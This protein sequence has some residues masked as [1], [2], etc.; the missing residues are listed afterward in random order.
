MEG[1]T[2]TLSVNRT[3]LFVFQ[4]HWTGKQRCVRLVPPFQP[5]E[6]IRE[7][8]SVGQHQPAFTVLANI[9]AA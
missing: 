5:S 7:N 3:S 1:K 4:T 9:L 6:I 8:V 2:P